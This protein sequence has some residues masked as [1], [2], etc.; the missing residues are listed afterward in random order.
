MRKWE[1]ITELFLFLLSL[2]SLLSLV[3]HLPSQFPPNASIFLSFIFSL[4]YIWFSWTFSSFLHLPPLLLFS[5]F[6][7][8][9]PF[10]SVLLSLVI[11]LNII[12]F[13]VSNYIVG[14]QRWDTCKRL[15]MTRMVDSIYDKWLDL[16]LESW[17]NYT[18]WSSDYIKWGRELNYR[19]C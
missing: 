18:H 17:T 14:S 12:L 7:L 8:V 19:W 13:A 9:F 11:M 1:R 3:F 5:V 10:S 15:F 6:P 16:G 2:N 4:T